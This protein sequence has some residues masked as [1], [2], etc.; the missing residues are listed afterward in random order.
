MIETRVLSSG[1][2]NPGVTLTMFYIASNVIGGNN[3]VVKLLSTTYD[4]PYYYPTINLPY[5]NTCPEA[6][7][8]LGG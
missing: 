4:D 6:Q 3:G 2:I 8:A 1:G 7:A 5:Y